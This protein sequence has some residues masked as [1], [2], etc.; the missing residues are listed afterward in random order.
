VTSGVLDAVAAGL[1]FALSVDVIEGV[2]VTKELVL[3]VNAGLDV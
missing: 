1:G 2:S 3:C